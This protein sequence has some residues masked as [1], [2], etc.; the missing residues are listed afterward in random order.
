MNFHKEYELLR[1]LNNDKILEISYTFKK[2]KI[3]I[4]FS[5]KKDNE[6]LTL[7]CENNNHTFVKNYGIY[8]KNNTAYINGYWEKYHKYAIGLKNSTNNR[9]TEFYDKLSQ[10]ILNVNNPNDDFEISYLSNSEGINRINNSSR[11]SVFPNEAIYFHHIRRQP[12]SDD[13]F[14]KVSSILGRDVAKY[15]KYSNLTAV[16]TPDITKQRSFILV[17]DIN[18]HHINNGE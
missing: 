7:V 13:Q 6:F 16:F 18:D 3:K 17:P 11:T 5:Q 10:I 12:I 9:F 14:K 1:S 15:L 8:F 2:H 4:Y